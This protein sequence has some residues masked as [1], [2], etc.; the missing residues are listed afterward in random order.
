MKNNERTITRHFHAI[1]EFA[2]LKKIERGNI[3]KFINDHGVSNGW[4]TTMVDLGFAEKKGRSYYFCWSSTVNFVDMAKAVIRKIN[5][6][7][8]YSKGRKDI[9][10]G[11]Y[12]H[13]SNHISCEKAIE[14]LKNNTEGRT[15]KI[16]EI[17]TITQTQEVQL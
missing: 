11:I 17:K 9:P 3:G 14:V 10:T 7:V 1:Q 5:K 6:D 2:I 13:P 16:I 12:Y 15:F 4:F 8:S